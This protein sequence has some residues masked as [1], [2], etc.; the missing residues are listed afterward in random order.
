ML[1]GIFLDGHR[2]Q[3]VQLRTISA[4]RLRALTVEKDA[5]QHFRN[6]RGIPTSFQCYFVFLVDLVPWMGQPLSQLAVVRKNKE[7]FALCVE[8][9][10]IEEARK[11][12][13]KQIENRVARARIASCGNET[14]RFMECEGERRLNTNEFAI[15]FDMIS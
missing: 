7:S 4:T 6:K 9:A 13:W 12:C 2:A 11:F 5:A 1:R 8:A 14:G 3:I 10:N 15:H